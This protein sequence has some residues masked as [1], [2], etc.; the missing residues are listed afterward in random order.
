L[1]DRINIVLSSQK[2]IFDE[3]SKN[4]GFYVC[5]SFE[6]ALSLVEQEI[7][8]ISGNTFLIGGGSLYEEG[9]N[10]QNC[11]DIFLKNIRILL[12]INLY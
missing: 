9:I 10:H 6:N 2:K 3:F 12:C 8:D 5:N 1:K 7:S 4:P 11:K